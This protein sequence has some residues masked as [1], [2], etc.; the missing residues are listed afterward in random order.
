MSFRKSRSFG[1]I[2][3]LKKVTIYGYPVKEESSMFAESMKKYISLE[4]F[5]YFMSLFYNL[6]K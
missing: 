2:L 3:L 1:M 4:I 5:C 6:L